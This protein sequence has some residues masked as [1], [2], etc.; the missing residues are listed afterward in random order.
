M[1]ILILDIE[2]SPNL[3]YVWGLWKQ[4]IGLN[5]LVEP[6]EVLCLAY[7]FYKDESVAFYGSWTHGHKGMLKGI[8]SA[9]SRCD[10]VVTYNG[11]RFDIPHLNREFLVNGMEPP[12]SYHHIDLYQVVRSRFRFQSNKLQHVAEQLGLGGKMQHSGFDLWKG[13]LAKEKDALKTMREYN[14]QDVE[15]TERV[16]TALLP[17]ITSHPNHGLYIDSD[18][19]VCPN[20]GS[21]KLT[22][23]GYS[24]TPML[25][26]QR[27]RCKGCGANVRGR[28]TT[29]SKEHRA[30]LVTQDKRG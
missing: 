5:Q 6:T 4:N 22:K 18:R 14:E 23:N 17:W 3:A 26:Y 12:A 19:P 24:S 2:T 28:T 8:H 11:K 9:L 20:C 30:Q 16:Y 29:L 15:L 21:D 13:C 25:M 27:Y 7:K 1:D 10:A